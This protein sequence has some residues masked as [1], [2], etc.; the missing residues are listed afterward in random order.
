LRVD[1]YHTMLL[2]G[3]E[4]RHGLNRD[5]GFTEADR[6]EKIRRVGEVAK[7]LVESGLIVLCSFISPYR[8]EREMVRGLGRPGRVHRGVRRQR[9][10]TSACG[11]TRKASTP[12]RAPFGFANLTGVGAPYEAPERPELH[13]MTVERSAQE[14]V[15]VV[16][17]GMAE[18]EKREI[19]GHV[20]D[21]LR[22]QKGN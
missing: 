11:A 7:I 21:P 19:G 8:A 20:R 9:R 13:L 3:D 2:D 15:E 18:R 1:G 5:L 4:V 16:Y 17:R 10:W 12:R 22:V 6:V 14:L